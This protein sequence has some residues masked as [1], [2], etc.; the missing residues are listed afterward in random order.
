[1]PVNVLP[2]TVTVL[3]VPT[4]LLSNV[5]TKVPASVTVS[6]AI[7]PPS[8]AEPPFNTA[9]VSRL[10]VLLAAVTPLTVTALGVMLAKRVAPDAKW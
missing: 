8:E 5:P 6:P 4:F 2:V 3:P 9:T 1:M 7:T 10:Y